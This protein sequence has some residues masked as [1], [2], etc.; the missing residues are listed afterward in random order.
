MVQVHEPAPRKVTT[1]S[2]TT[3]MDL[4]LSSPLYNG[5]IPQEIRDEIFTYA[6]TEYE[7]FGGW[8]SGEPQHQE[9]WVRPEYTSRKRIATGLLRACKR[10]YFESRL[11]PYIHSTHIFWHRRGPPG[12]HY[13]KPSTCFAFSAP[14]QV[15]CIKSI[16]IC[17]EQH[18]HEYLLASFARSKYMQSVEK[19]K[20]TRRRGDWFGGNC[21]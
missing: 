16:H 1:I 21:Q 19:L 2:A 3:N 5:L 9:P 8:I 17:M 11:L 6:M 10:S 4:Q 13:V 20:L 12:F 14:D 7:P 18:S 15:A